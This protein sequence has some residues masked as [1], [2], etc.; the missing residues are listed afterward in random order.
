V[1]RISRDLD[2]GHNRRTADFARI[3]V[4]LGATDDDPWLTV[5]DNGVGMSARV[6]TGH[7]LNFG[8]SF[9]HSSAMREDRPPT[10]L[11]MGWALSVLLSK[12]FIDH[13]VQRL[14]GGHRF[15]DDLPRAISPYSL[16]AA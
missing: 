14:T 8:T 6:L 13:V 3:V 10:R 2:R 9:W 4:S 11:A 7:L 12:Q 15:L 1:S 16:V 5:S